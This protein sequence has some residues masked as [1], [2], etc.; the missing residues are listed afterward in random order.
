[1]GTDD[2]MLNNL[3]YTVDSLCL[4]PVIHQCC[5]AA[6]A[7][8]CRTLSAAH[9]HVSERDGRVPRH[10]ETT[11]PPVACMQLESMQRYCPLFRT[12]L[13]PFSDTSRADGW[14]RECRRELTLIIC[15][16]CFRLREAAVPRAD[17]TQG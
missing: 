5:I 9:G 3:D 17:K 6:V 7:G 14:A 16:S 11:H 13:R 15:T 2:Y 4:R 1:M 8:Q 10:F 12:R